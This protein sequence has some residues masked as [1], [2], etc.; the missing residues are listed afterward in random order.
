MMRGKRTI[1]KVDQATHGDF[2]RVLRFGTRSTVD[3]DDVGDGSLY[4]IR[5]M[6][7]DTSSVQHEQEKTMLRK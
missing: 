2:G 4:R 1:S 7:E 6:S 5:E 3:K